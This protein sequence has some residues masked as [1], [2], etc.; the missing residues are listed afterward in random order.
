VGIIRKMYC[1]Y[2]SQSNSVVKDF[3]RSPS[4]NFFVAYA[5]ISV[6]LNFFIYYKLNLC[7]LFM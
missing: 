3:I 1:I 2:H 4:N 6:Y 5:I 7:N